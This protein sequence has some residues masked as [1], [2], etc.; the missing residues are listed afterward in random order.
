M[1]VAA[2]SRV[3]GAIGFYCV[4]AVLRVGQQAEHA[5][6]IAGGGGAV[7]TVQSHGLAGPPSCLKTSSCISRPP[8]EMVSGELSIPRYAQ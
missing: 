4:H 5:V 8:P 3:G 2:A 7:I 6:A 1:L